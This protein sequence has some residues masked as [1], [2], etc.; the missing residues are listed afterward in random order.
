[1]NPTRAINQ[2][3]GKSGGQLKAAAQELNDL[4]ERHPELCHQAAAAII[5]M[6]L[7]PGLSAHREMWKDDLGSDMFEVIKA[8]WQK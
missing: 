1:M 7:E 5:V 6:M 3:M 4:T 2:A 8:L